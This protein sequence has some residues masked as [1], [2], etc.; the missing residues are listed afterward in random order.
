M[1]QQ[2]AGE[3]WPQRPPEETGAEGGGPGGRWFREKTGQQ[4]RVTDQLSSAQQHNF[5]PARDTCT[6]MYN[7]IALFDVAEVLSRQA[8][9][10][11]LLEEPAGIHYIRKALIVWEGMLI[12]LSK[13]NRVGLAQVQ[14]VVYTALTKRGMHEVFLA[15]NKKS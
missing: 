9:Y 5:I 15:L 7:A 11:L 12:N 14:F 6:H 8:V 1:A 3:D 13:L 4:R 10:D 2:G